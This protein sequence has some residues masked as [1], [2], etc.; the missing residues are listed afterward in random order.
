MELYF[1]AQLLVN[2]SFIRYTGSLINNFVT[3]TRSPA[4]GHG[5]LKGMPK[6]W[7]EL[8]YYSKFLFVSFICRQKCKIYFSFSVQSQNFKPTK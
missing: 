4:E 6:K 2:N 7:F 3:E 5:I 8:K 1:A